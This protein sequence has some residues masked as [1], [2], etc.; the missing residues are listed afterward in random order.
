MP[1]LSQGAWL[2]ADEN[3]IEWTT[4]VHGGEDGTVLSRWTHSSREAAE[5]K[6]AEDAA[7]NRDMI[8]TGA[9]VDDGSEVDAVWR[10]VGPWC[11]GDPTAGGDQV[12]A[13]AA[14]NHDRLPAHVF[15]AALA[16]AFPGLPVTMTLDQAARRIAAALNAAWPLIEREVRATIGSAVEDRAFHEV[17][18]G[19]RGD[20]A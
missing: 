7:S 8:R 4:R 18:R 2:G 17:A 9:M 6:A 16:A 15:D 1:E 14:T 3:H 11:T 5:A 20:G 10:A 13:G 12:P 19:R